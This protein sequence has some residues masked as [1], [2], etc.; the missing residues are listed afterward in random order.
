E[1]RITVDVMQVQPDTGLVIDVS[2]QAQSYRTAIAAQCVVYGNT[3]VVC[4]PEKKINDEEVLV[5]RLLGRDFVDPAQIDAK[6]HWRVANSDTNGIMTDDFTISKNVNGAMQ[7]VSER[8]FKR[9]GS[10]IVTTTSDT[11]IAYDFNR[12]VPTSISEEATTREQRGM[13]AYNTTIIQT[14]LTLQQDS[15]TKT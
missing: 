10:E 14:V 4:D 11:K 15:L 2:E 8:V 12:T 7:I 6:N 5:L 1:R 3:N 9:L 13:S